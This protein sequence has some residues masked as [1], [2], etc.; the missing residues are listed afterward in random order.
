MWSSVVRRKPRPKWQSEGS[1]ALKFGKCSGHFRYGFN[2]NH[3]WIFTI[4]DIAQKKYVCKERETKAPWVCKSTY[5]HRHPTT[6]SGEFVQ[7]SRLKPGVLVHT[8]N[9]PILQVNRHVHKSTSGMYPSAL[10][11]AWNTSNIQQWNTLQ[12]ERWHNFHVLNVVNSSFTTIYSWNRLPHLEVQRFEAPKVAPCIASFRTRGRGLRYG[13]LTIGNGR[14]WAYKTYWWNCRMPRRMQD[15]PTPKCHSHH[16]SICFST[17]EKM[18][19][20]FSYV[21]IEKAETLAPWAIKNFQIDQWNDQWN[22]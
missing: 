19:A 15:V 18:Y 8:P 6:N 2:R 22:N 7:T 14:I 11:T 5:I 1:V 20:L 17:I 4:Y 12:F 13:V 16:L 10:T 9:Y 21:F 3:H